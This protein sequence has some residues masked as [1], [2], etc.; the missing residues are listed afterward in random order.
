MVI[1]RHQMKHVCIL[2]YGTSLAYVWKELHQE[3]FGHD[4]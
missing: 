4:I 3:H 1:Q 2:L